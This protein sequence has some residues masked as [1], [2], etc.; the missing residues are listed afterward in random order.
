[1]LRQS[2]KYSLV[3]LFF[4]I[5]HFLFA[6]V[7]G[8][9]KNDVIEKRIE[10]ITQDLESEDIDF[11]NLFDDLYYF[12]DNPLDVN[13]VTREE[14]QSLLMLSDFQISALLQY[15]YKY[16]EIYQI[17]ELRHIN[18]WDKFTIS[19][20]LPFLTVVPKE[21]RKDDLKRNLKYGRQEIVM[22]YAR[23]LEEQEGFSPIDP[24]E[25]AQN[26]NRRFLG[27]PNQYFL[28][29]RFSRRDKYSIGFTAEKDP[30]EEF[31][32][33]SNPNGFDFYSAH[34]SIQNI[35]PIKELIVGD[36]QAQFGQG[37]TFWSGFGFRKSVQT[38]TEVKRFARGLRAYTSVNEN[39]FLRG[40]AAQFEH[41]KIAGA[42]FY[43]T[44]G[45]DANTQ[46]LLDTI[47]DEELVAFSSLQ[48]TGFHRTP[49]EV[50]N[51][52]AIT[53]NNLG[54]NLNY[55]TEYFQIGFT[56]VQSSF[57]G[58]FERSLQLYNQFEFS[59]SENLVVGTD[60][61]VSL[62][63]VNLFGEISRSQNGGMAH[64]HGA[65]IN[66]EERLQLAMIYRK[67]D[68]D[69]QN[70]NAVPFAEKTRPTNEEGIYIGATFNP[71]AKVSITTFLDNYR[72][73]WLSFRADAPSYGVEFGS[74]I[75]WRPYRKLEILGLY[76]TE[77]KHRNA[78]I[79]SPINI[80][81]AQ[82]ISQYRVQATITASS[83]IT[84]RNRFEMRVYNEESGAPEY[85]YL[86]FQ[87]IQYNAPKGNWN[88]KFRYALFDVESFDARVYVYENDLRYQFSVP[89][90][91]SRGTRVYLLSSW[92][93]NQRI[94]W[95]FRIA[96]TYFSN[97]DTVG[98]GLNTIS[99][100]RRTDLKTQLIFKF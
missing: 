51:K 14:M 44:K 38:P 32:A 82:N 93:I 10:F 78:S 12:L 96:Q 92:K 6:Q 28:R 79:E 4:S 67:F 54:M 75:T 50:A 39:Q 33:G 91:S 70:I 5:Q 57:S 25:L 69:F 23:V 100:N 60:Y 46:I 35:G 41:K 98:S 11:T 77:T 15:R 47:N 55:R 31:F 84:L 45:V 24:D 94:N 97:R 68:R 3:L 1:M 26:P 34:V 21:A 74:Q 48:L 85:G 80:L 18:G 16:G 17:Q 65:R 56:A 52:N 29:Y 43:S 22:R 81:E 53:E 62:G 71:I 63:A 36:Y 58:N 61:N 64:L 30:G 95:Q 90:F 8:F 72:F 40:A 86:I 59:S 87:D 27:D 37:L 76:R 88:L 89:A 83:I 99:G 73:P 20:V 7:E 9:D 13:T 49:N 42:V 19:N 2:L 66:A